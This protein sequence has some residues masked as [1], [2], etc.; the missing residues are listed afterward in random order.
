MQCFKSLAGLFGQRVNDEKMPLCVTEPAR[1]RPCYEPP[2]L[3][4]DDVKAPTAEI[5]KRGSYDDFT[6]SDNRSSG[7]ERMEKFYADS[8]EHEGKPV[9]VYSNRPRRP[10]MFNTSAAAARFTAKEACSK[11]FKSGV[12]VTLQIAR[13]KVA[14]WDDAGQSETRRYQALCKRASPLNDWFVHVVAQ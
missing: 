3:P 8:V 2:A 7:T 5:E 9:E 11:C 10:Q 14:P 6:F 12:N 4:P 1:Q 13:V